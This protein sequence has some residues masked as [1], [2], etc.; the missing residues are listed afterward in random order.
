[1]QILT[2]L[3]RRTVSQSHTGPLATS[4]RVDFD[5]PYNQ[6]IL[7]KQ[8]IV[9]VQNPLADNSSLMMALNANP[10]LVAASLNGVF[11]DIDTLRSFLWETEITTTGKTS[12]QNHAMWEPPWNDFF[13]VKG[14]LIFSDVSVHMVS[15]G[16]AVLQSGS[17]RFFYNRVKLDTNEIAL[18][19]QRSR[20]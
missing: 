19:G 8:Y 4:F 12:S 10:A 13:K 3:L 5:L 20:G 18:L 17:H 2:P 6:G 11:T 7:L 14:Y 1:M 9:E 15:L 16:A